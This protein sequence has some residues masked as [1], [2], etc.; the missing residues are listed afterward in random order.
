MEGVRITS[1]FLFSGPISILTRPGLD[2]SIKARGDGSRAFPIS[3]NVV[4]ANVVRIVNGLD[5]RKVGIGSRVN[6]DI[7]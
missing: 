1:Q 7:R 6:L 2:L 4:A 5:Q 3:H